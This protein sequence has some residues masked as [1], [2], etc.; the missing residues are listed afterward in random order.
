MGKYHRKVLLKKKKG[1]KTTRVSR[2]KTFKTE[3]AANKYA[4]ENE[5]KDYKLVNLSIGPSTPKI[6]IVP[7]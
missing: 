2:P 1:Y 5:M 7:N 6:K 3:D 4:K